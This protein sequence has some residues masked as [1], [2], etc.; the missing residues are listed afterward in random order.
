MKRFLTFL[1]CT[2]VLLIAA[3]SLLSWNKKVPV[4]TTV[5]GQALLDS[6]FVLHYSQLPP[7]TPMSFLTQEGQ[8]KPSATD[9]VSLTDSYLPKSTYDD[10]LATSKTY[11]QLQ[12][13]TL[14]PYFYQGLKQSRWQIISFVGDL[15][16][17]LIQDLERDLIYPITFRDSQNLGAMYPYHLQITDDTLSILG[18]KP[19]SDDSML[20]TI[21][22]PTGIVQTAYLVADVTSAL[23]TSHSTLLVPYGIFLEPKGLRIIDTRTGEAHTLSIHFTPLGITS[24][25]AQ[26][27]VYG[28]PMDGKLP[29]HLI[30]T[31]FQTIASGSLMLPSAAPRL[32]QTFLVA[33]TVTFF[34]AETTESFYQN[35]ALTYN[36]SSGELIHCV[37]I[38]SPPSLI[39]TGVSQTAPLVH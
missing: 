13:G 27:L 11:Y 15:R 20:Y 38:E 16:T 10:L 35:Y 18:G 32:I 12:G 36:L 14:P 1:G 26:V 7:R 17:L 21:D 34:T 33:D 2:F 8:L 6:P 30:D 23:T 19:N 37:G 29:Y 22:L 31:S 25:E 39:L 24:S 9:Y 28:T 4:A 3:L 5:V